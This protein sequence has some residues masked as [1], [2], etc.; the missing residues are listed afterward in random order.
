MQN[1]SMPDGSG[2]PGRRVGSA[3]ALALLVTTAFAGAQGPQR[4]VPVPIEFTTG[5]EDNLYS[6]GRSQEDI[7]EWELALAELAAGEAK[8]AVERLH[9][10]LQS[11]TGGVVP[12]QPGRFLGLRLAVVTTMANMPPAATEA[13]EALVVRE[14]G[15]LAHRPLHELEP[16]QLTLLAN[17]FPVAAIGQRARLRLGDLAFTA[18]R[19]H[20]AAG[21]Y[22]QALDATAI[23]SAEERRIAERLRCAGVLTQPVTSRAQ[24]EARTL[25]AASGDVLSVLPAAGDPPGYPAIGGGGDGR[26]PMSE[27]AGQPRTT[28][29]EDIAALGYDYPDGSRFAMFPVGDLDGVFVN[30]G[31]EVI[32]LDPLRRGVAWMSNSPLDESDRSEHVNK[33]MVLAAACGGDYVVA[34]LQVPDRSVNVDFQASFRIISKIPQRR[35]HA[36]SRRTGKQVWAH[37]D[38]IDG[39]RTRRFRGH[40]S[41]A[42]PIV[43]GDTVYA[44]I[45]DRSGAIAF[46][47]GAYDVATG[48]PRWRRLVCSSQQDVNMFGNARAEYAASPLAIS[49]GVLYGATNLGVTFAVEAANGR[50]RWITSYGVVRMPRTMLQGQLERPVFFANNA[51]V[52]A[53]GVVCFTPLDSQYVLGIDAEQGILQW[54]LVTDAVVGAVE[55]RV[56]WLAGALDD[57]FVLAG[58]GAVA[59]KARDARNG[60]PTVRQ[61]VRPEQLRS[62]GDDDSGPRPAVTAD[63]VWFAKAGRIT[64]FDRAG[65]PVEAARQ[66]PVPDYQPGNLLLVDGIVVSLRQRGLD[67]LMDT[68][69]LEQRIET[70]VAAAPDDPA[71]ILRLANLRRALLAEGADPA[72][73]AAMRA[74]FVRGLAAC[75]KRGMPKNHPTRQALQRALFAQALDEATLA[76]QRDDPRALELLVL[77]REAAPEPR[78]FVMVQ[79]LVLER[80][81]KD[82]ARLRAELDL[83]EREAGD[84]TMPSSGLPVRVHVAWQ[85]ALLPDL[86]PTA[87]VAAWQTLLENHGEATLPNG[88]AAT[89]AETAIATSMAKYGADVYAP[90]AV[91]A[92]AALARAGA[93]PAALQDISKRFPN[94]GAA[95]T[96]RMRLLDNAVKNGDLALAC[97]VFARGLRSGESAPGIARRVLV[98][99]LARGNRGLA[100]AMIARL[101]LA[102]GAV[103]DWPDDQG[104]TFGQVLSGIDTRSTRQPLAVAE[105]PIAELARIPVRS[106][107]REA[108]HLLPVLVADGFDEPADR[109]LFAVLGRDL[110]AI[111]VRAQTTQKPVLFTRQVE[112]LL[113]VIA[114]GTVLVVPDFEHVCGVDH[115]T[116]RLLWEL[117]TDAGLMYE[118]LGVQS[119]VL[120][121]FAFAQASGQ[122]AGELLGVEP[123]TG[124]VLFRRPMAGNRSNPPKPVPGHLIA[125]ETTADGTAILHRIDPLT[126]AAVSSAEVA[127]T[128]L[129]EQLQTQGEGVLARM[130][131][132]RLCANA[133]HVFLPVD[134]ARPEDAPRLLA[135]DGKGAV[136]WSWSGSAGGQLVGLAR[137]GDRLVVVESGDQGPGRIALLAAADGA[138]LREVQLGPD[139]KVLNWD[140]GWLDHPAPAILAVSDRIDNNSR[141]RRFVA[142]GVDDDQPTVELPLGNEDGEIERQPV[143]GPDFV[144]FGVRPAGRGAFRLLCLR[145]RDRSGALPNGQKAR[146]VNLPAPHGLA[147]FG[148]YT[149]VSSSECLLVLG[150]D[151]S[152]K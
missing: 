23:G 59:V 28:T 61:L 60:E 129:R 6:L 9:R 3:V 118:S 121:L 63:H 51:P 139:P 152:N 150:A 115:R 46:S 37:F 79:A 32:A 11:E 146:R 142:F 50:I 83:L 43:V 17:R 1:L 135:I 62:R 81:A 95:R 5:D 90:F 125:L 76:V 21:H 140:S 144:T 14:A 72:A 89:I 105:L 68:A 29:S 69:A 109:P 42:P 106:P 98:A 122:V 110:Q 75:A 64:G 48:Q 85:R 117:P 47:V 49:D 52:L 74:L 88:L 80:C 96:A 145:L 38:E 133:A 54:R 20:E 143:F 45:H 58:R 147:T 26:L 36:F 149:V 67:I 99:A 53:A 91:R 104:A 65:N 16:D 107:G 141:R 41:C 77:A 34:A 70:Q 56:R 12:V 55:N 10:L 130:L 4:V 134:G 39:Q 19:G 82:P 114:C 66:I 8:A 30:T 35:L 108:H 31:S 2:V 13:Y 7:H 22:R 78:G 102:D 94:S 101:R 113:H 131:P 123:L 120:H 18:G 138:L 27:P 132:Q 100:Q 103:S 111:D 126:G 148:A 40:D 93:D 124:T 15:N 119:G 71:A 127:D 73:H 151:P 86:T 25:D 112:S 44:P 116:G 97:D 136:A 92:D 128:A 57:E 33:D 24:A 84:T 137:R 87:A